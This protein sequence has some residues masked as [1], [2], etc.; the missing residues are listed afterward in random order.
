MAEEEQMLMLQKKQKKNALGLLLS[1]PF[2]PLLQLASQEQSRAQVAFL[3]LP[4]LLASGCVW[5]MGGT[6]GKLEGKKQAEARVCVSL[7]V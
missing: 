2:H 4:Y 6:S 1:D 3:R 5:S 7:S